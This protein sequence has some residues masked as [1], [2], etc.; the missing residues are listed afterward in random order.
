MHVFFTQV[1]IYVNQNQETYIFYKSLEKRR[2]LWGKIAKTNNRKK[3]KGKM[4]LIS[5]EEGRRWIGLSTQSKKE[6]SWNLIISYLII[7][8]VSRWKERNLRRLNLSE[9]D[10]VS[11]ILTKRVRNPGRSRGIKKATRRVKRLRTWNGDKRW[12]RS[13]EDPA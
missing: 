11:R 5:P 9:S 4:S 12:Q 7:S 13:S 6:I 1:Y 8:V 2:T 10:P 3:T